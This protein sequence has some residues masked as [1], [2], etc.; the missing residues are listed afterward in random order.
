MTHAI[1]LHDENLDTVTLYTK[2]ITRYEFSA[3]SKKNNKPH[4]KLETCRAH[5]NYG[6]NLGFVLNELYLLVEVVCLSIKDD[7]SKSTN[8]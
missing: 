8:R 6:I 7:L 5:F 2:Y 1:L 3:M 4:S